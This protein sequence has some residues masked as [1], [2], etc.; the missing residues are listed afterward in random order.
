MS[1]TSFQRLVVQE[2]G[3]ATV[4][5]LKHFSPHDVDAVLQIGEELCQLA[6]DSAANLIIDFSSVAYFEANMRGQLVRVSKTLNSRGGRLAVCHLPPGM[7]GTRLPSSA[8]PSTFR[9][10]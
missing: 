5:Q 1:E 4:T 7:K 6:T 8:F 3:M 2:R 9:L 10:L